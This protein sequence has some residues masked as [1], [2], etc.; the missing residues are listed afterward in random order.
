MSTYVG[1]MHLTTWPHS[2]ALVDFETSDESATV[3]K[4]FDQE[5]LEALYLEI[6]KQLGRIENDRWAK[7]SRR[8]VRAEASAHRWR[9]EARKR[10]E[11]K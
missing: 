11:Q 5:P 1:L 10:E 4:V 8:L 7:L 9:R 3:L 6:G 2:F